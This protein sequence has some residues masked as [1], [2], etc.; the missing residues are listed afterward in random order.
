MSFLDN[1]EN[2]LKSLEGTEENSADDRRRQQADKARAV[3]VAPWAERLKQSSYVRDL[4][5]LATRAGYQRRAKVNLVWIGTTL[6]LELRGD[7]LELRPQADG[8]LAVFLR[9]GQELGSQK[10]DLNE[11]P[12]DLVAAW[13]TVMEPAA[14][15]STS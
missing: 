8:V 4:M 12:A 1:L 15:D 3:A 7:R 5:S 9:E 14:T 2:A 6:R 10:L 11:A 13:L